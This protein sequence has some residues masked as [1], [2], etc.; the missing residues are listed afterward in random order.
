M[1]IWPLKQTKAISL[2]WERLNWKR[3]L[4]LKPNRIWK[5]A[6]RQLM[7][8]LLT[9]RHLFTTCRSRCKSKY[10]LASRKQMPQYLKLR[11]SWLQGRKKKR[12]KNNL[13]MRENS[14]NRTWVL[15]KPGQ[16][17]VVLVIQLADTKQ[18]RHQVYLK[19][20]VSMMNNWNKK[21]I[22]RTFLL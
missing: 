22:W 17:N 12:L 15:N 6:L 14:I 11:R 5:A 4:S 2:N 21:P 13:K 7:S 10:M 19:G 20:L 16:V 1:K 9:W 3:T 8:K 18:P